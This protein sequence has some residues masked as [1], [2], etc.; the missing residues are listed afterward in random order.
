MKL[1]DCR[2]VIDAIDTEIVALLNRRADLSRRI[3]GMKTIAG[4]PIVD[5]SREETV[6]RRVVRE[7]PGAIDDAALTTI[8]QE[9]LAESRRIQ[10]VVALEAEERELRI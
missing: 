9:I 1:E 4:L 2:K 8:Y 7:N 5:E 3:G 10:N 6:I